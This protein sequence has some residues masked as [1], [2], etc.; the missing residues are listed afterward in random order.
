MIPFFFR[1]LILVC[2]ISINNSFGQSGW[3][4]WMELYNDGKTTVMIQYETTN[5]CESNR[6]NKF[7]YD[8]TGTLKSY[9]L[10]VVYKLQYLDC[11]NQLFFE[12]KSI[13]IGPNSELGM[14][15][16]L[17]FTFVGMEIIDPFK[18]V[19]ISKYEKFA[20]G[21]AAMPNSVAP[22]RIIGDTIV[23]KGGKTTLTVSGGS[24]GI[25]ANW[26]WYVESC[27]G[28]RVGQ[29]ESIIVNVEKKST[30]YV[31]AEGG[32]NPTKCV[33]TTVDVTNYSTAPLQIISS[34][35]NPVCEGEVME[36]SLVGGELARD[37]NW[38][39]YD[40]TCSG[41]K[42]GTGSQLKIVAKN[43]KSISIQAEGACP[44]PKCLTTYMEVSY[45][46]IKP[47]KILYP[48]KIERLEKIVLTID[49]GVLGSDAQW[50]WYKGTIGSNR[51]I[52]VG[53][54]ISVRAKKTNNFLIKA[55]GLCYQT[56]YVAASFFAAKAHGFDNIYSKRKRKIFNVGMG[57]G[58]EWNNFT[59]LANI[60]AASEPGKILDSTLA[61]LNGFGILGDITFHPLI[62][63]NFSIGVNAK[64]SGG[65]TPIIFLE[66]NDEVKTKLTKENYLYTKIEAGAELCFG[67]KPIK[68]LFQAGGIFQNNDIK[69][70]V[71][72]DGK[73]EY[74]TIKDIYKLNIKGGLRLGS[75]HRVKNKEPKRGN[76]FDFTYTLS[77]S[78]LRSFDGLSLNN[79][80][81]LYKWDP[82]IG[83]S[84]WR[85]S[86]LKLQ[87]DVVWTKINPT[88]T[89]TQK[90]NLYPTY[91][92][93]LVYNRN[94]FY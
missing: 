88:I 8:I 49:G 12:E 19:S 3:G 13:D 37:A 75:Y 82:G 63:K 21:I 20:S 66:S 14:T 31:R 5:S 41:K 27:N 87:M 62:K 44:S 93:T 92:V 55:S 90:N 69:F 25:K 54:S 15:E 32:K 24:L 42:I 36:F 47:K 30:Y 61:T 51:K 79:I 80:D 28:K 78:Y 46:S 38:V 2:L 72:N 23:C 43:S 53:P 16:S 40:G 17:N 70:S 77:S 7:R 56:E 81:R 4:A 59:Q 9:D 35:L 57:L 64:L 84:W 22:D 60:S 65:T 67:L 89:Q 85:Q 76:S 6:P 71:K 18:D 52:G 1:I 11:N 48:S 86:A 34:Q 45:N 29:G 91:M 39:W 83:F 58:L 68:L 74:Y 50:E 10:F 33:K 73:Q 94:W 26:V